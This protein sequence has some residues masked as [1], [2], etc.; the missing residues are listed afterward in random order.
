MGRKDEMPALS[1][2]HARKVNFSYKGEACFH[3]ESALRRSQE[4]T[5]G[6]RRRGLAKA[7]AKWLI[8]NSARR[9]V[10]AQN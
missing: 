10:N 9:E 2:P 6:A 8:A 3:A 1:Q 5:A 4:N 7:C